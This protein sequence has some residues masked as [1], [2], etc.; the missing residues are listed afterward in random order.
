MEV[1][2]DRTPQAT[3]NELSGEVAPDGDEMRSWYLHPKLEEVLRETHGVMIYQEDVLRVAHALA[4]LSL[5]QADTLR[6][7][8]SGKLRSPEAMA[9]VRD[10]F[11]AGCEAHAVGRDI[12]EETWRQIESFAGYAFC[13]AHSA[14]YALLSFQVAYLKAHH[15]AEFMAAVISNQGG[16]Y[17]TSAYIS[18]SRRMGLR[19]LLPEVNHSDRDYVGRGREIRM[20]LMAFAGLAEAA[21]DG[22]LAARREG[23]PFTNL[24]DLLSRSGLGRSDLELL[25]RGGACDGFELTRPELLWRLACRFRVQA[26]PHPGPPP[27][28]GRGNRATPRPRGEG[29]GG[30]WAP[31]LFPGSGGLDHLVPRLP[32]YGLRERCRMEEELFG[33][34][35]TRHPL[36]L[37]EKSASAPGPPLIAAADMARHAG[38]RVRM[39][40]LAISYKRIPTKAGTWMKFLS[41]E[42]LTG[43]FEAVLFP[44]AYARCA[45]ATLGTG[46]LLVEGR[47]DLD[48][49]VP[50]LTV[51]GVEKSPSAAARSS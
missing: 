36:E 47:I 44:D 9:Q 17:A 12:A 13:K 16:F 11:I 3:V 14:S 34:M 49:G 27:S 2:S 26:H 25:V 6:R 19:I 38:R 21:I 30:G 41:L 1:R 10:G 31:D 24:S 8:M 20:G 22:L 46:P 37:I 29:A 23:G 32:E 5:G 33:F 4:G 42:D 18:E 48:H 51:T 35:V 40:G 28:M 50:S 45:E 7:S 39:R 15:P 43:T